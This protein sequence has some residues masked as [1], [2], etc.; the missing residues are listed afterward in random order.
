MPEG[1]ALN[2]KSKIPAIYLIILFPSHDTE[3]RHKLHFPPSGNVDIMGHLRLRKH[4]HRMHCVLPSN[5]IRAR[6]WRRSLNPQE[7]LLQCSPSSSIASGSLFVPYFY[8][9]PQPFSCSCFSQPLRP[10]QKI[11]M[12]ISSSYSRRNTSRENWNLDCYLHPLIHRA[13]TFK[14]HTRLR[15]SGW[16]TCQCNINP[17]SIANLLFRQVVARIRS[18]GQMSMFHK[19]ILPSPTWSRS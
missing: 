11:N 1:W 12:V 14:R 19:F 3:W 8:R 13:A 4:V 7:K 15:A 6:V 17:Q 9:Y 16:K 2:V 10:R 18:G 5:Y